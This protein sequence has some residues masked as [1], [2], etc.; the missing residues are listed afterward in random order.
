MYLAYTAWQLVIGAVSA[1]A[2]PLAIAPQLSCVNVRLASASG[3]IGPKHH[4]T[5]SAQCSYGA[6][7]CKS[8]PGGSQCTNTISIYFDVLGIGEWV[9]ATGI[10]TET[11]KFTGS[12]SGVR[13]A[14]GTNCT[15]DPWLKDPPSP[16]SCGKVTIT[17]SLCKARDPFSRS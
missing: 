16:G 10:A 4:Y 3:V 12:A 2:P 7:S 17:A 15:Q 6:S 11:L 5:F 1:A 14:S 8:W 13:L 9:R